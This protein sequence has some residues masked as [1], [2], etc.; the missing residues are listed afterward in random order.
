[1]SVAADIADRSVTDSLAGA[2]GAATIVVTLEHWLLDRVV[3]VTLR[4]V[5]L[6]SWL[7]TW[8]GAFAVAAERVALERLRRIRQLFRR[9]AVLEYQGLAS[10]PQ[11]AVVLQ[12]AVFQRLLRNEELQ[13]LHPPE[14]KSDDPN[15]ERHWP[16]LIEG[17]A[18]LSFSQFS[19]HLAL[20]LNNALCVL[21][22]VGVTRAADQ[23]HTVREFYREAA[24]QLDQ[25]TFGDLLAAQ[26]M[27]DAVAD[28][29]LAFKRSADKA[30]EKRFIERFWFFRRRWVL[31]RAAAMKLA[32]WARGGLQFQFA[33]L[34]LLAPLLAERGHAPAGQALSDAIRELVKREVPASMADWIAWRVSR[35]ICEARSPAVIA[36]LGN[37]LQGDEWAQTFAARVILEVIEWLHLQTVERSFEILRSAAK[38]G[39]SSLCGK[40]ALQVVKRHPRRDAAGQNAAV[41]SLLESTIARLMWLAIQ[42]GIPGHLFVGDFLVTF[43]TEGSLLAPAGL[44]EGLES[45][46]LFK[47]TR[48]WLRASERENDKE[49]GD[50]RI[51]LARAHPEMEKIIR[52]QETFSEA[53]QRG[54]Q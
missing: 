36:T 10:A 9:R 51:S 13:W 1:M 2:G 20:A 12:K 26:I 8:R 35:Q 23:R 28:L 49:I 21:G 16:V 34:N 5:S 18:L 17:D 46:E 41:W 22:A 47:L 6:R 3:P 7:G 52:I 48:E 15:V 53:L 27:C 40:A 31:R 25:A 14:M 43:V 37:L 29:G 45:L 38:D 50:L 44:S 39:V 19:V 11:P 30:G 24:R 32:A 42:T 4:A 33:R 54:R